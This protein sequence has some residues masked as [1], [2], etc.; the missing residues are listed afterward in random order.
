MTDIKDPEFIRIEQELAN[1][2]DQIEELFKELDEKFPAP[3]GGHWMLMRNNKLMVY[4]SVEE[5]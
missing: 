4:Y 5:D 2:H 1:L 3:N